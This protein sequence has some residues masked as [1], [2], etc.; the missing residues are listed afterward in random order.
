MRASLSHG[1]IGPAVFA[2]IFFRVAGADLGAF[3]GTVGD[4]SS[5]PSIAARLDR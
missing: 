2:V 1:L 4:R 5:V 3:G